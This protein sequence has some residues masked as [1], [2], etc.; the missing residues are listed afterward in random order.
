M[1]PAGAVLSGQRIAVVE[2]DA[3]LATLILDELRHAGAHAVALGSAEALYRELLRESFDLVVLDVGLP[4]EDGHS[5]AQYL[6]QIAPRTGIVMLTGRGGGDAMR[7]GLLRGA[8]LFLH[9]PLDLDLLIAALV[10]LC[11][12]L[13][14]AASMPAVAANA[15]EASGSSDWRLSPDGWTLCAPELGASRARTLALTEA[16]RALL[17]QLF[18]RRGEPVDRDTLVAAIAGNAA[19]FDPHRLEVLV[20]RLRTRAASAFDSA[21]PLRA[22][23]GRGYLIGRDD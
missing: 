11:R 1:Q 23:R 2:D 7:E 15:T 8:D 14:V 20:H 21:L 3:E 17:L 6:H 18:S 9:K 10:S 4:G 12:R 16:E 22:V 19:T 5:V 13:S